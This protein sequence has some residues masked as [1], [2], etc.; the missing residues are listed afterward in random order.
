MMKKL[1]MPKEEDLFKMQEEKADIYSYL[2]VKAIEALII[3][4][5]HTSCI[6]NPDNEILKFTYKYLK[7]NVDIASSICMMYPNE[8]KYSFM[9]RVDTRLCSYLISH[10]EDNSIY[11]LDRLSLFEPMIL[12]NTFL[13]REVINILDKK[14]PN[15]PKYRFEY[16]SN[17]LL[18]N[19]FGCNIPSD[20][21]LNKDDYYALSRIEPYYALTSPYTDEVKRNMLREGMES[22]TKRYG[23]DM[24]KEMSYYGRDILTNPDEKVR[25]LRKCINKT[26]MRK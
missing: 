24:F 8:L 14:L 9:A 11:Q 1:F 12:D 19:I 18:D 16:Q 21:Y 22:Y 13:L 26:I 6:D 2:V 25:R 20:C 5:I 15:C 10:C 3:R 4:S 7:E 17:T 23:I